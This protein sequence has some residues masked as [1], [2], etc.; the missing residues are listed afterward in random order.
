LITAGP[1][2][3]AIDSVRVISNTASGRTGILLARDFKKLGA[4]VT[5][6]LGP[7]GSCSLDKGIKMLRFSF[8][9]ELRSL[10]EREL[11]CVKYDAVIHTAAVS[12]YM[13]PRPYRRKIKSGI[14][15]LRIRL[16]PTPKIINCIKRISP[17]S[18]A[19]GFKF[20]PQA[21]RGVLLR[22][23]RGLM[24]FARL[25][26]A[27]ANTIREGRYRAYIVGARKVYGPFTTKGMMSRGLERLIGSQLL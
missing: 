18:L 12:D 20:E 11:A 15:G 9:D 4:K 6:L 25:D 16:S 13:A 7:V 5:L 26:I 27:V 17:F 3:A 10:L 14:K 22:E 2:W 1:T 21:S 19:V 23:A 8:F 24:R